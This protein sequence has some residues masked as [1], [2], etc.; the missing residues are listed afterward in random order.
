MQPL[1]RWFKGLAKRNSDVK[2]VCRYFFKIFG[3]AWNVFAKKIKKIVEFVMNS[4]IMMFIT[5]FKYLSKGLVKMN[6]LYFLF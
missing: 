1:N 3:C 6:T 4:T 5:K 2:V